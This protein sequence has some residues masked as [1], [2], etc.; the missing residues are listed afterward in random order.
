MYK[1]ETH[2]KSYH[3]YAHD[4]SD[5]EHDDDDVDEYNMNIM[6]MNIMMINM[7][8]IMIKMN[9]MMMIMMICTYPCHDEEVIMYLPN[10][11]CVPSMLHQAPGRPNLRK[12]TS[13][14]MNRYK[15]IKQH[16]LL[17]LVQDFIH[18]FSFW[19]VYILRIYFLG[20]AF[21]KLTI[22]LVASTYWNI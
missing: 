22:D 5:E 4:K 15:M 19:Y 16:I 10:G 8:M 14:T 20:H 12:N 17:V 1:N 6:M 18:L 9:M 13:L 21:Y 2:G 11:T 3:I 7:M